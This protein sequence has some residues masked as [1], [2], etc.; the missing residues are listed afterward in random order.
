MNCNLLIGYYFYEDLLFPFSRF[1]VITMRN[2][3]PLSWTNMVIKLYTREKQMRFSRIYPLDFCNICFTSMYV[4][5]LLICIFNCRFTMEILMPLMDVQ[6]FSVE[7]DSH[8]SKNM[9]FGNASDF[10]YFLQ[11]FFFP[12]IY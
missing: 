12:R 1:K 4:C 11:V 2:F 3:S 7:I 5:M 6:H 8:M 9:R 10:L